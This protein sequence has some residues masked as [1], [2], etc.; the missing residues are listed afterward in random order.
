MPNYCFKCDECG[1]EVEEQRPMSASS[2]VKNCG[3]L[4]DQ[5][6]SMKFCDGVLQRDFRSEAAGLSLSGDIEAVSRNACIDPSDVG[7]ANKEFAGLAHFDGDGNMHCKV[8]DTDAAMAKRG[9]TKGEGA[10]RHRSSHSKIFKTDP[11]TGKLKRT[12]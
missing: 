7:W 1:R 5:G 9:F 2:V 4:L 3:D 8:R 11:E 10:P 12:R 6:E